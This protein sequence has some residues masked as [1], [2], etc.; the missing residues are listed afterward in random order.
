QAA[1]AARGRGAAEGLPDVRSAL[2]AAR[3]I[4][5]ARAAGCR[6]HGHRAGGAARRGL[7]HGYR[8]AGA[9]GG[10][11]RGGNAVV[12]ADLADAVARWRHP[13]GHHSCAHGD[14][15]LPGLVHAAAEAVRSAALRIS[16]PRPVL[17]RL[18][19]PR[20]AFGRQRVDLR[21][22]ADDRIQ[23]GLLPDGSAAVHPV[24]GDRGGTSVLGARALLGL[25]L[26]L[27]RAAGTD[28]QGGALAESAADHGALGL[29]RASMADQIHYLPWPVRRLALF[30][31]ARRTALGGRTLQDGDRAALPAGMAVRGL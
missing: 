15:L 7:C 18:A 12:A 4:P 21:Q 30:A 31:G 9:D 11:C 29:A 1:R 6:R 27:R 25:A 17:A 16:L 19:R 2:S 14:L 28:E 23:V 10:E 20:A 24:G 3:E 22:C 5:Q 13:R 26:S 8:D